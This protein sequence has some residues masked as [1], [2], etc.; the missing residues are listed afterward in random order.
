MRRYYPAVLHKDADSDYG[1]SFPDLPGCVTA[2]ADVDAAV[3]RA[4]EALALHVAGMLEDGEAIPAPSDVEAAR[5][6]AEP[7]GF[8]AVVLVPVI[9]PGRAK[10][11]QVTLPE[12]LVADI[13]AVAPNRSGFLADAA[14]AELA[15]RKGA[16][17]DA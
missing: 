8:R 14:R 5:A 3:R 1:L 10:R 15:R 7:A 13:D 12:D 16:A 2:A 11:Y 4:E 9:I 17:A 6:A